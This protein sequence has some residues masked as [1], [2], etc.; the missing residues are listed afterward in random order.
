MGI[1]LNF[2]LRMKVNLRIEDEGNFKYGNK[3]GN[4]GFMGSFRII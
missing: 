1:Y 2:L 4:G 3:F